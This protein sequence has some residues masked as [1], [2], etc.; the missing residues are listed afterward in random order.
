ML[1][2]YFIGSL[3]FNILY[4]VYNITDYIIL[5]QYILPNV[6]LGVFMHFFWHNIFVFPHTLVTAIPIKGMSNT[7][8]QMYKTSDTEVRTFSILAR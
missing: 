3:Y 5:D 6:K 4:Y 8:L 2:L 7:L 1:K